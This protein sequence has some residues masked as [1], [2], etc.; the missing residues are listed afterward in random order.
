MT[1]RL[2]DF[3]GHWQISRQIDDRRAGAVALFEGNAWFDWASG[4]LIYAEDGL[5]QVPGQP[6]FRATRRYIWRRAK[7]GIAVFFEDGR[8]FH[9]IS[10]S[11]PDAAHWCDPDDYRVTYDFAAWP[12]WRAVWTVFGPRK[13]YRMDSVYRKS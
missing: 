11:R 1:P 4:D 6:P 13:D 10:D 12:E 3:A 2:E 5:L 8:P 9:T 7:A